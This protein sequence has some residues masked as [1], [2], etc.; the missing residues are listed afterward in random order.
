VAVCETLGEVERLFVDRGRHR[1][2]LR[3]VR[4]ED[5]DDVASK[6]LTFFCEHECAS[7]TCWMDDRTVV[8]IDSHPTP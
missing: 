6:A 1:I 8:F 3:L 4:R 2:V 7:E 5:S